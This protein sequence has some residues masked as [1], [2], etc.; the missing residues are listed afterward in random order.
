M[1][2]QAFSRPLDFSHSQLGYPVELIKGDRGPGI[3]PAYVM[4]RCDGGCGSERRF[5]PLAGTDRAN[6]CVVC[7]RKTMWRVVAAD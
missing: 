7:E 6:W 2:E 1:T 3:G 4:R 5:F